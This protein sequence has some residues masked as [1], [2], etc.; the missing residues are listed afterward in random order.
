MIDKS[1]SVALASFLRSTFLRPS[2]RHIFIWESHTFIKM[3]HHS[4]KDFDY[5]STHLR[6]IGGLHFP[7]FLPD[8]CGHVAN[9]SPVLMGI[10]RTLP[11]TFTFPHFVRWALEWN[12]SSRVI[13]EATCWN[14]GVK[15]G[16][17]DDCL[18]Q[19]LSLWNA[20]PRLFCDR[21]TPFV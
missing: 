18:E 1:V 10:S 21:W 5:F 6:H 7:V 15:P 19:N 12:D 14:R 2:I 17:L 8:S 16:V 20:G 4:W 9:L 11:H 3:R 13:L